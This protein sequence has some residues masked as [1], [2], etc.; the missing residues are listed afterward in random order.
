MRRQAGRQRDRFPSRNLNP[1]ESAA[2]PSSNVPHVGVTHWLG[3][4]A[5]TVTRFCQTRAPLSLSVPH[6]QPR[7]HN[8]AFCLP[9]RC[10]SRPHT[11]GREK[12]KKK[13]LRKKKKKRKLTM[14]QRKGKK[15]PH[16]TAFLRETAYANSWCLAFIPQAE[17]LGGKQNGCGRH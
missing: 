4:A 2:Q 15:N 14:C 17:F 11:K 6:P 8:E 7:L 13:A 9:V 12:K 5:P 16:T 1:S 3:R 10:Y